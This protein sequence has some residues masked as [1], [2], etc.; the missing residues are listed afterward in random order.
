VIRKSSYLWV[1]MS[2]IAIVAA[3]LPFREAAAQ[4]D[5]IAARA[6]APSDVPSPILPMVPTVAPGYGAPSAAPS[7][8]DVA[9]VAQQPFVGIS[10]E[11]AVGMALLKNPSLAVSASNAR[12]AGYQIVEAKGAFDVRLQVAP[13]SSMSVS[14]PLNLFFAGPGDTN[15][16]PC[17]PR[18]AVKC[19][20]PVPSPSP[21]EGPG[22]IIQHQYSLQYGL[23]GQTVNGAQF[24]AGIQQTRT[25]NNTTFDAFNP[26]YLATLNLSI[27]QPLLRNLGMNG[28]KRQYQLAIVNTDST[29]AQALV[30]ASTTLSQVEDVYWSLAA[31][32]RDVAIQEAALK[33]AVTE[34]Q[35]TVRLA[36]RGAAAPVDVTEAGTQVATFQDNV[37]AA[38]QSVSRLQNQLKGLLVTS[39]GDPIWRA[40]LVPTTSVAEIPAAPTLDEIVADA[41]RNRPEIRQAHDKY[42]QAAIDFSFAKNQGLPQLDAQITYQSNG[43]AGLLQPTPGIISSHCPFN[44]PPDCPT[45]P[46]YTQ[47]SMP[48][49]YHNLWTFRYPTFNV[50]VTASFPLGNHV[51]TGLREVAQEEQE[52][53]AVY[54]AGVAARIGFDAR[55]ALQTYQSA[56]SRLYAARIAREASEQVY[57]SEVRKYHNGESTTF[58]VLRRQVELEQNRG[59]ELLAQTDLN[60]AMVE[61]D[62]VEGAILTKNN[63]NVRSLG[64]QALAQSPAPLPT[65]SRLPTPYPMSS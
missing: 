23:G 44:N 28:A 29:S 52:Q 14:P 1:G 47:G 27:T 39:A 64:S 46:P 31:A 61:I 15:L 35:S 65:S 10:L 8:A 2:L 63:V 55:N 11:D 20:E 36:K 13:T 30:D 42:R 54:A 53:A 50:S 59:R 9:G 62:R 40:N 5:P 32:W 25:Y 26:Y 51:A 49:A 12:I 19:I 60:K 58:L 18:D 43:F 16:Y 4:G 3:S 45:P 7:T 37:F 21:G 38:V 17:L 41:L 48:Q 34:Q 56:L 57:A 33:D 24:S 22:N 6:P